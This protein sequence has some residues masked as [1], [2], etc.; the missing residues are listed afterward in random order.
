M[1]YL[2]ACFTESTFKDYGHGLFIVDSLK[3]L[4]LNM[5]KLLKDRHLKYSLYHMRHC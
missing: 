1:V 4:E 3:A 5:L 2:L